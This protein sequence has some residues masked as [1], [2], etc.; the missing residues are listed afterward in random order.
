MICK[1]LRIIRAFFARF[2]FEITHCIHN[3][4]YQRLSGIAHNCAIRYREGRYEEAI[5]AYTKALDTVPDELPENISA[6]A[7]PESKDAEVRS[8][9]W[10]IA[11]SS[12]QENPHTDHRPRRWRA[13]R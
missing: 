6:V 12:P 4:K 8:R 2:S 13:R 9:F 3:Q 11:W 5:E 10:A 7:S 1:S